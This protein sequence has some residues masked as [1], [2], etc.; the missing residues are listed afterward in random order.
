VKVYEVTPDDGAIDG[1]SYYANK[2]DAIGRAEW[3]VENGS[4]LK[5]EVS[6]ITIR[7]GGGRLLAV[8]LLNRI[9]FSAGEEVVA[10]RSAK[11]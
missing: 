5:A 11:E 1:A 7:S 9:G 10:V 6:C 2:R 3:L 8:N 4:T